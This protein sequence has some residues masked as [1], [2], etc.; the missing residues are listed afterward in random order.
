[1][2]V[3]LTAEPLFSVG[4]GADRD[5]RMLTLKRTFKCRPSWR[6]LRI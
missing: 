1:M 4:L 6:P 5:M 2:Q 3:G